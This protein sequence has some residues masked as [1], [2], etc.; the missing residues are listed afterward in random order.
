MQTSTQGCTTIP[1]ISPAIT[2]A[3]RFRTPPYQGLLSVLHWHQQRTHVL[4]PAR[5]VANLRPLVTSWL[6]Q[7]LAPLPS[8]PMRL[9]SPP[10]LP[11]SLKRCLYALSTGGVV[12]FVW[13]R[14]RSM[15]HKD[16]SQETDK[17]T[18]RRVGC[19]LCSTC[20]LLSRVL[21]NGQPFNC[22]SRQ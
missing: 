16:R 17:T 18:G 21:N 2:A 5:G 14:Q 19:P 15:V 22:S 8:V 1:A 11:V 3:T 12:G 10:S 7:C 9:V 6:A 4:C 13:Q 20:R